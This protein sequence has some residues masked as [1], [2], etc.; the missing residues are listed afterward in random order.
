MLSSIKH[1]PQPTLFASLVYNVALLCLY[2]QT[3]CRYLQQEDCSD[4]I[5]IEAF[6][7][8]ILLPIHGFR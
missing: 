8:T 4:A 3:F 5:N 1:L 6:S 2:R 7:I